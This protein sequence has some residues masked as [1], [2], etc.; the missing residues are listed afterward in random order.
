MR[1]SRNLVQG[2]NKSKGSQLVWPTIEH[3]NMNN[4]KAGKEIAFPQIWWMLLNLERK[5]QPKHGRLTIY[6]GQRF[7]QQPGC[8]WKMYFLITATRILW[9]SQGVERGDFWTG[10]RGIN[11]LLVRP[12]AKHIVR[13][14]QVSR[15]SKPLKRSS[16]RKK[17]EVIGL[18]Q[19]CICTFLSYWSVWVNIHWNISLY[20]F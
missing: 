12:D 4:E 3:L 6:R 15:C 14:R 18:I 7:P 5:L 2:G 13:W 20:A 10:W 9:R 11:S 1:V 16:K 8:C 17:G 19:T